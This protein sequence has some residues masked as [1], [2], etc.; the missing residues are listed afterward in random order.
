MQMKNQPELIP[1]LKW[2]LAQGVQLS[3]INWLVIEQEMPELYA[4]CAA[5][6]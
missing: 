1:H 4:S 3:E 5:D 6:V 2:I